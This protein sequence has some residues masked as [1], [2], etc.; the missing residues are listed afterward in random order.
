MYIYTYWDDNIIHISIQERG[1]PF[2]TN[3]YNGMMIPQAGEASIARM[4][5]IRNSKELS[6]RGFR[7][8]PW[9]STVFF[10]G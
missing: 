10:S 3:Q 7:G 2:F 9:I 8:S 6:A 4:D 5:K 1:I